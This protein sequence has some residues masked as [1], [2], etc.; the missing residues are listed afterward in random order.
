MCVEH[1]VT[2]Y[3]RAHRQRKLSGLPTDSI[4]VGFV[5][6]GTASMAA[7]PGCDEDDDSH[8]SATTPVPDDCEEDDDSS[9]SVR[10]PEGDF[11][12]STGGGSNVA[13]D[14][15]GVIVDAMKA[16][17][18]KIGGEIDTSERG[19]VAGSVT[20]SAGASVADDFVAE[21]SQ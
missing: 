10:T 9:R 19:R 2:A 11:D 6:A 5:S 18:D 12:R 16:A 3:Y 15:T 14:A 8:Q 7:D 4:V 13:E 20:G 1:G 17:H 21:F